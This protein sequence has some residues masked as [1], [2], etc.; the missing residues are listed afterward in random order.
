MGHLPKPQYYHKLGEP[1]TSPAAGLMAGRAPIVDALDRRFGFRRRG[2]TLSRECLAGA[3]TYMAMCYIILVNPAV[4]SGAGMDA[5]AVLVATCLASAF[6]T[7]WMALHAD[8]PIALAPGMGQNFFFAFTICGPVAVGGY[9]YRWQEAL[10]A[11]VLA[12]SLFVLASLWGFRARLIAI[13]PD[14]LKSSL[15][16]GIGLLIAVVGLRWGGLVVARPGTYIGLGDLSQPA[17]LLTLFGLTLTAVLSVLG[18]SGALVLGILASILVAIV[19][20]LVD[21]GGVVGM[22]PSLG[23]TFLALDFGGLF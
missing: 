23:P 22:P 8:Y 5:G 4:L 15:G 11:V 18:I 13:V 14:H 12:G 19:F 17:V 10:A 9:G 3:T 1:C 21:F 2:S 7:L 16:V 6:A 20:G